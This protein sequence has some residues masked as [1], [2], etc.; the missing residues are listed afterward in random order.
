MRIARVRNAVQWLSFLILMYGGR[1]G[2]HLGSSLPCFAC[3]FVPGCGGYC[4]LMGLQ[5]Y[6]GFGLFAGQAAG[7]EILVALGWFVVFVALVM[8]LGKA[9]CGWVCPFGLIQDWLSWLR[10]KLGIR[11][12]LLSPKAKNI[13][14]SVKYVF[15]AVIVVV[16]PLISAKALPPDL[17][18]P[19]CSIC[20]GK[21]LLPLFAGETQYLSINLDNPVT[22]WVSLSLIAVTAVSLAGAFYKDRFYCLFCPLLALIHVLRPLTALKL[23]KEPKACV[24]CGACRRNCQMDVAELDQDI[25]Q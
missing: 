19:F 5:G 17:Y 3:P 10:N 23:V 8:A 18:L 16:P 9:W 20:P 24:G 22:L 2:I 14:G 11:E 7:K 25:S 4:Y 13:L 21:L 1:V 15:L 12:R 6:I